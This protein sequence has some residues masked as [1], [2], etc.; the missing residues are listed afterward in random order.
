MSQVAPAWP[1]V[2]T[3]GRQRGPKGD[4]LRIMTDTLPPKA[5]AELDA[6]TGLQLRVIELESDARDYRGY[7]ITLIGVPL[8][9]PVVPEPWPT[10]TYPG[11]D[12]PDLVMALVVLEARWKGC[13]AFARSTYNPA[14]GEAFNSI[15]FPPGARQ[16][17][18]DRRRAEKALKVAAYFQ[19][20]LSPRGKLAEAQEEARVRLRG[21]TIKLKRYNKAISRPSLSSQLGLSVDGIAEMLDRAGWMLR[22]LQKLANSAH[23]E[24]SEER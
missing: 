6:P 16:L 24:H 11:A 10:F 18:R 8:S 1:N 22:D 13:P 4:T 9:A 19:Q 23:T 15:V 3:G 5:V 12:G 7:R 17:M 21:A 20:K 2:A 14:T